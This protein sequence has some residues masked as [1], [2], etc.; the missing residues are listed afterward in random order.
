MNTTTDATITLSI[1]LNDGTV[2]IHG[3]HLGT[4]VQFA[5]AIA[6][7][8]F[9]FRLLKKPIRSV[10]LIRQQQVLAVYDGEWSS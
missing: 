2:F 7:D 6:E 10:A 1:E 9:H 4:D 5:K 3:F 8:H